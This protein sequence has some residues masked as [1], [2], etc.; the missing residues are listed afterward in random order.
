MKVGEIRECIS[1]H[2]HI[3]DEVAFVKTVFEASVCPEC[4]CEINSNNR[5]QVAFGSICKSSLLKDYHYAGLNI[6]CPRC[7]CE[8]KRYICMKCEYHD[9][10]DIIGV[11]SG[12]IAI[13][14]FFIALFCWTL[15]KRSDINESAYNILN[16]FAIISAISLILGIIGII[17][18]VIWDHI[19]SKKYEI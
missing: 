16:S 13:V 14:S 8:F 15:S 3:D 18:C 11:P 6:E 17:V 7:G 4:G 5:F 1:T 9:I 12:I 2:G 19:R 10:D